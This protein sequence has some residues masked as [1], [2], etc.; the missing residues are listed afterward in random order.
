MGS[1][2]DDFVQVAEKS[3][4]KGLSDESADG[5]FQDVDPKEERA[6]VS[7]QMMLL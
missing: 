6:F 3:V 2:T 1:Q 4:T 5:Q 7:T